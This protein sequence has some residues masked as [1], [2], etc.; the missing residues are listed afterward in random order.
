LKRVEAIM[1]REVA[2]CRANARLDEV[3]RTMVTY[4]CSGLPV[5]HG[6]GSRRVVGVITERDIVRRSLG[7][8]RNPNGL[9]ASACM[10]PDVVTV[11]IDADMEECLELME[12]YHVR[13]IPVVDED[14]ACCGI[15]TLTNVAESMSAQRVGETMKSITEPQR[16]TNGNFSSDP[17]YRRS[18]HPMRPLDGR[19][20][21]KQIES[22]PYVSTRVIDDAL[23][24]AV[25]DYYIEAH[26][27]AIGGM[28]VGSKPDDA[29]RNATEVAWEE[30]KQRFNKRGDKWTMKRS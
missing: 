21:R 14:R 3:V 24:Q 30:V 1:T 28:L 13:R 22:L 12:R 20:K 29:F 18:L 15:V 9:T 19:S 11:T 8:G 17:F 25:Q 27:R 7:A 5:L 4:N 16:Q 6:D 26:N 2:C 10:T 23:P